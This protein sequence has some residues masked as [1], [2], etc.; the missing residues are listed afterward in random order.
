MKRKEVVMITTIIVSS[1]VIM[2]GCVFGNSGII[3][4]GVGMLLGAIY[5]YELRRKE[6]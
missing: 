2:M 3:Y 1:A 5:T 4:I 6:N